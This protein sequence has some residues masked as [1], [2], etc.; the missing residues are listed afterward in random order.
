M[1][2]LHHARRSKDHRSSDDEPLIER[3]VIRGITGLAVA[4][5]LAVLIL[6]ALGAAC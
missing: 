1:H 6:V 5:V 4:T 3:I 2:R